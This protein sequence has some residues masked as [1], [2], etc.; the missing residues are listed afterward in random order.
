[1]VVLSTASLLLV[2]VQP[3]GAITQVTTHT[4]MTVQR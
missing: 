4:K 3:A 2:G 1:V